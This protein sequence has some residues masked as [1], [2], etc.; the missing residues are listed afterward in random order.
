MAPS[1]PTR[2]Y[3]AQGI[4]E[5]NEII[6][7]TYHLGKAATYAFCVLLLMLQPALPLVLVLLLNIR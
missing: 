3:S 6:R 5:I 2:F 1:R 4:L 7:V